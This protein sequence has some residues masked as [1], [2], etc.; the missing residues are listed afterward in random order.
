MW[1]HL[2]RHGEPDSTSPWIQEMAPWIEPLL[3]I[4]KEAEVLHHY[5]E[6]MD[7]LMLQTDELR[8]L[9]KQNDI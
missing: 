2:G 4:D 1:L 7:D 5:L 3:D 6:E 8:E 9:R